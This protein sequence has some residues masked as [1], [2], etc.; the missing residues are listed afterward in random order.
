MEQQRI[1]T[2]RI[3]KEITKEVNLK[4]WLNKNS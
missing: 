2:D 1:S 4:N 3:S